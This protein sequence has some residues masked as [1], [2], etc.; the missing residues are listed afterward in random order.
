MTKKQHHE[1]F[2]EN[3]QQMLEHP[4]HWTPPGGE[5]LLRVSMRFSELVNDF[6]QSS[7]TS[8]VFMTHRDLLWSAHI[9]L[10]HI[11]LDQINDIDT[12]RLHNGYV[13]HYTNINPDNGEISYDGHLW[14]RSWTPWIDGVNVDSSDWTKLES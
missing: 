3:Y 10:D 9:P 7:A 11:S 14:K 13:A 8:G 4:F 6:M 12:D 1:Q 2:P 5:S